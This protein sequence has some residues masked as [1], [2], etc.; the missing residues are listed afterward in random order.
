MSCGIEHEARLFG[1]ASSTAIRLPEGPH[2]AADGNAAYIFRRARVGF[3]RLHDA[4]VPEQ[5][6]DYL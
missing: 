4:R 6:Q 1:G 3:Y 2:P 5:V